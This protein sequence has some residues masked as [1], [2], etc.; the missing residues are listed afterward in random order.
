MEVAR[1]P[2]GKRASLGQHRVRPGR[3]MGG[4]M[5]CHRDGLCR[6]FGDAVAR[7]EGP[8]SARRHRRERPTHQGTRAGPGK[9]ASADD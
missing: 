2:N 1:P 7:S 8:A 5:A 9:H 6:A 3:T 4:T